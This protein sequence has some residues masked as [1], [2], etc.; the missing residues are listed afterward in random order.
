MMDFAMHVL[1]KG[2]LKRD[3]KGP[4]AGV[5]TIKIFNVATQKLQ[6]FI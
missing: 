5:F 1:R 3:L 6:E 2:I 4:K